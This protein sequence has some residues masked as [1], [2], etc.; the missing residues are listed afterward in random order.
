MTEFIN[1]LE[2][3]CKKRGRTIDETLNNLKI[4]LSFLENYQPSRTNHLRIL[5]ISNYLESSPE[6]LINLSKQKQFETSKFY[7]RLKELCDIRNV[8]PSP[9]LDS[10][11]ISNSTLSGWKS[12]GNPSIEALK[13]LSKEFKCSTDYLLGISDVKSLMQNCTDDA[14]VLV[15]IF[16]EMT[17]DQ[18]KQLFEYVEFLKYKSK[19]ESL[20]QVKLIIPD[21]HKEIIEMISKGMTIK[22]ISE[23]KNTTK[24]NISRILIKYKE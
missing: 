4:P 15:N 20:Q 1:K 2:D 3:M 13:I 17:Q 6:E 8:K 14:Y 16:N 7:Y 12:G 18:K 11:G 22:Q 9:M 23:A 5:L 24:Q 21:K 10:I 19:N